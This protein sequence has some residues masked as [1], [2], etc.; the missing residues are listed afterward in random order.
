MSQQVNVDFALKAQTELLDS[1]EGY[2]MALKGFY[3]IERSIGNAF[4]SREAYIVELINTS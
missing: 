1:V 2:L 4:K 3:E